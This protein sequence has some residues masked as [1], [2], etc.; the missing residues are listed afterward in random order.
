LAELAEKAL[1]GTPLPVAPTPPPTVTL[2]SDH[3]PIEVGSELEV[4]D[5]LRS[6]YAL[7]YRVQKVG[8]VTEEGTEV[9]LTFV[10]PRPGKKPK[11]PNSET[12]QRLQQLCK[13]QA[14][15][16]PLSYTLRKYVPGG[17]GSKPKIGDWRFA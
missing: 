14:T 1:N 2:T 12:A 6:Q 13:K 16:S 10:R 5:V 11:D 9:L 8:L 4:G 3:P 7:V 15:E 17:L